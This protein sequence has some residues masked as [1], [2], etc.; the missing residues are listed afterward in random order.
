M[1]ENVL[2]A[3]IAF[4]LQVQGLGEW[5][6]APMQFFSFLGT[7]NF[8]LL[9][10]PVVVWCVDFSLGLRVGLMLLLSGSLNTILKLAFHDPRPFWISRQVRGYAYESSFGI[11]S[12]HAQ[13]AVAIWGLVA[14]RIRKNW[15][16]ITAIVVMALIGFSRAYLGVHFPTDVL[17][18]WLIGAIVLILF[19]GLDQPISTWLANLSFGQVGVV[20]FVLSAVIIASGALI[21]NRLEALGWVLPRS[22]QEN[23]VAAFPDL[24]PIDPAGLSGLITAG[25]GLFGYGMGAAWISRR[26]G[27][28]ASGSLKNLTYRYGLG[29]AGVLILA[30]GLGAVFPEGENLAAYLL[31]F[32]RYALVTGWI[33]GLAPFLFIRLGWAAPAT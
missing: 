33:S 3:G 28:D 2:K 14:A 19:L 8:Y 25:A 7:E 26:G 1:P 12:G 16:W 5:L 32:L 30:Y 6:Q 11:P 18:G 27:F 17:V 31:R 20:L 9:L 10:M 24:D 21:I 15:V 13:N 22:W 4:I 29:L 23:A